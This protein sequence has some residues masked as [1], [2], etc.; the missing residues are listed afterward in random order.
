MKRILYLTFAALLV[1][2]SG[3]S[4]KSEDTTPVDDPNNWTES[5]RND[6][7]RKGLESQFSVSLNTVPA[8]QSLNTTATTAEKNFSNQD[9]VFYRDAKF[10]QVPGSTTVFYSSNQ[11]IS[12]RLYCYV[13]GIQTSTGKYV[14]TKIRLSSDVAYPASDGGEDLGKL[15]FN[16]Q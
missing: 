9:A 7:F 5:Q 8:Y 15:S 14:V 4:K 11:N 3:C 2:G 16:K 12:G 10:T 6:V 1:L 13:K